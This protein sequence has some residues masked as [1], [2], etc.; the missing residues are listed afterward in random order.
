MCLR[1]VEIK[2]PTRDKFSKQDV[3]AEAQSDIN[4]FENT[5][6]YS[7]FNPLGGS[8]MKVLNKL[9]CSFTVSELLE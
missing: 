6:V 4:S 8:Y 9:L 7:F 3:K 5:K 2:D 1:P